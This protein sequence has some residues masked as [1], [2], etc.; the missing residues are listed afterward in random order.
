MKLTAELSL[1]PVQENYIEVIQA[2]IDA[3]RAYPD[4]QVVTNAMSTQVC[5]DYTQVFEL[6]S[7]ALAASMRRFGK[8]VLVVK[9]IPW[10]LELTA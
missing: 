9:F 4:L 8:Q 3:V 1:Y 5:G 6:V 10:E 2:F 7:E